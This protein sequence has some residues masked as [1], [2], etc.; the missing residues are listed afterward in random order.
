[1]SND[2]IM[3]RLRRANPVPETPAGDDSDLFSRLTASPGDP[4]VTNGRARRPAK[5]HRRLLILALAAA[6]AALLASTAFALSQWLGGDVVRPPVTHQEYL[7]A[8]KLLHLPPGAAWPTFNMPPANTVTTR[9][10]GGGQAV[11]IAMNAW[12]CYWVGAI[13]RGDTAAG[14]EAHTQLNGFLANNVYEAPEGAPEGWTPTPFPSGPFAVFAN[15][16]GLESVRRNYVQ[17]AA[18]HPKGLEQSCRANAQ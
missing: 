7:D 8:Q 16:G 18:G 17:A 15:D 5:S 11:L 4:R 2:S 1:M 9:G 13:H 14:Q 3:V 10:G 6:V 12:E